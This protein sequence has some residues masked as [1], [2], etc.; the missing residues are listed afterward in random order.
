MK[1]KKIALGKKLILDKETIADLSNR[2]QDQVKGMG[3]LTDTC[4]VNSR[5]CNCINTVF[6]TCGNTCLCD[7]LQMCPP[8]S[9]GQPDS[10]C[11]CTGGP[12]CH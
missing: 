6:N 10:V 7:T 4:P 1:R 9:Q 8:L 2:Q 12:N 5:P 3:G 11:L